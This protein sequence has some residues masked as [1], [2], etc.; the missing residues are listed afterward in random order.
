MKCN[1]KAEPSG[2]IAGIN[3]REDLILVTD[4][5]DVGEIKNYFGD[6]PAIKEFDGFFVKV[7]EGDFEEVY[8]FHG[9]VP[10]LEKSLFKIER[11]CK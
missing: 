8:G 2:T 9:I 3:K 6:R 5:Q 1:V 10:N 11:I 7:G 4:S